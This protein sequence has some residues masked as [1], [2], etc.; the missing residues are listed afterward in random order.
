M[1]T[2]R[3]ASSRGRTHIDWLDS[4]HSFSFG[5]YQD[6]AHMNFR[7]LRVI[8]DDRVAPGMGFGEHGHRDMEI[9]SIV[10]EG[11]LKHQDSLGHG[12]VLPPGEVQVMTAGKGIR[13]SEFNPSA[14]LP[15]HFLQVWI[16]PEAQGL[17]PAYGQRSFPAAA[18]ANQ[19]RRV[20]GKV[21]VE[22]DGA[23][24][25]NQDADLFLANLNP[26]GQVQHTLRPGRAA[27]IHIATGSVNVNG[28]DLSEG[29]GAAI[30][31]E[32]VVTLKGVATASEVLVFDLA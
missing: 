31:N 9:I 11:S 18:R 8:N 6:P 22:T 29:D 4:W 27:Y 3:P 23:L 24:K 5:G 7:A 2:T 1:I 30:E 10:L 14:D 32:T 12:E 15:V 17:P 19:L 28:Q 26:S 16:M 20:A 25:I 21:G 13:H